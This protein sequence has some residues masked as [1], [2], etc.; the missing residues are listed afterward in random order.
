MQIIISFKKWKY[1]SCGKSGKTDKVL[2]SEIVTRTTVGLIEK[3]VVISRKNVS[4]WL[5]F[6]LFG[7]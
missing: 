4:L 7:S 3:K 2:F 1:N 5:K 6:V